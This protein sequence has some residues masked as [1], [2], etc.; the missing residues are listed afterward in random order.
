M[1]KELRD[2]IRVSKEE[3]RKE[4]PRLLTF[5]NVNT[6]DDMRKAEAFL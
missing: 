6:E 1:I 2:I 3:L 5:I 4:D